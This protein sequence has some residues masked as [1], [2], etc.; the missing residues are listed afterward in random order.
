MVKGDE[1]T[2]MGFACLTN[3]CDL[4]KTLIQTSTNKDITFGMR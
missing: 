4:S 2:V 3:M 1:W